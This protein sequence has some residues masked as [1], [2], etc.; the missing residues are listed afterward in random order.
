MIEFKI[1]PTGKKGTLDN[2]VFKCP[3]FED[4]LNAA[5]KNAQVAYNPVPDLGLFL[6][7]KER[8]PWIELLSAPSAPES[9][10]GRVY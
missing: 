10:V 7:V 4:A 9:V 8:Y 1:M 2:G 6:G 5:A 3:G